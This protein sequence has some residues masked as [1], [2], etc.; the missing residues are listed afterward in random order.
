VG[1]ARHHQIAHLR[2][3]E[4]SVEHVDADQNLRKLDKYYQDPLNN[5]CNISIWAQYSTRS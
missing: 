4:A 1:E 2:A 5:Y 3:V